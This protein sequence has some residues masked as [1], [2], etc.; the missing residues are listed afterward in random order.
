MALGAALTGG[1]PPVGVVVQGSDG[2]SIGPRDLQLVPGPGITDEV[3]RAI[4]ALRE[5]R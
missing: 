4:P 3:R 1:K 2:R 5:A